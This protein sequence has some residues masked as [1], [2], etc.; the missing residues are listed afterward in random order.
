M[1]PLI[2][3]DQWGE[4]VCCDCGR[5]FGEGERAMVSDDEVMCWECAQKWAEDDLAG[6]IDQ[7]TSGDARMIYSYELDRLVSE[8]REDE[9]EAAREE[10]ERIMRSND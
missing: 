8:E 1:K 5:L 9:E 4:P 3:H 2:Y 6:M 10:Y 7:I